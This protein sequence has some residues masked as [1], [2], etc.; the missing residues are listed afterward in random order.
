[1]FEHRIKINGRNMPR[2]L[3]GT[4]PFIGAS[5]FGHRARLYQLDLYQK[6]EN[7]LKIIKESYGLGVTGIQLIPY[8]PV[9]D[10][11]R[12]AQ[13]QGLELEIVGTVRPDEEGDIEL[14]SELGAS[15]MLLHAV[16]TDRSHW[17]ILEEKI[18]SIKEKNAIPGLVTHMPFRTTERLLR[19]PILDLFDIYMVPVNR[20]GYLM[21]T[22]FYGPEERAK[23]RYMLKKLDKKIIAKKIMA[24]GIL[25]PGE[26][27][28]Y[29]KTLDYVDMVAMGIASEE[30][31]RETFTLLASK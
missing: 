5:Q 12:Q 28:D 18:R 15:A 23:L 3:L 27:F 31:A 13:E 11:V 29:L 21:D 25:K 4:S 10:A 1:M 14:L 2:T 6:P 26:A 22:E 7:M 16:I 17:G 30:E 8:P 20:L 19:S 24:A 9:V